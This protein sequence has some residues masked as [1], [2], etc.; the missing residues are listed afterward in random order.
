MVS[1]THMATVLMISRA[2]KP[3]AI[4]TKDTAEALVQTR[5]HHLEKGPMMD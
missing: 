3:I 5:N 1:V 2:A 4:A